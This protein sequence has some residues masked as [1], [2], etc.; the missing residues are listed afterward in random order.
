[1]VAKGVRG[2]TN[3]SNNI[4]VDIPEVRQ[5]AEIRNDVSRKLHWDALVDDDLIDVRVADG[6]VTLSGTVGSAAEKNRAAWNAWVSGVKNVDSSGLDVAHWARDD[7]LR[8]DKYIRRSDTEIRQAVLDALLYDPRVNSFD[9]EAEVSAG[10]VSLRGVV[11]NLAA[12][13][14]A[15]RNARNTVGVIGVNNLIKVRPISDLSDAEI[16]RKVR[17]ALQRNPYTDSFEIDVNVKNRVVR[18]EGNVDSYFE[19]AEAENAAFMAA[20]VREVRNFL[21][22]GSQ[23]PI[24][25][26]PYVYSWSI[27]EYPWYDGGTVAVSR[28]DRHISQNVQDEIFWSPFVDSDDVNVAVDDGVVTLTGTVDTWGEY[29]AAREN[30]FEGGAIAVV[31]NLD[32][33]DD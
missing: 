9:L 17:D 12:R 8:K 20:G 6:T 24:V 19:K 3:V 13:N 29:Q 4:I 33:N 16:E 7:A 21:D 11:D 2:V 31:N 1:M 14:A 32:V 30:A 10:Q 5:D 22:V 27:H 23:A 15:I 25:Y 28:T 18:L 26:D